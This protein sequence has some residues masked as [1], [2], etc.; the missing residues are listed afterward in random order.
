MNTEKLN[1]RQLITITAAAIFGIDILRVQQRIVLLSGQDAW[2]SITIGGLLTI[3]A[4]VIAYF[5]AA[6]YPDKD[7]PEIIIEICGKFFGKIILLSVCAYVLLYSGFSSRIFVQALKMFLVDRTPIYVLVISM[8]VAT[9]YAAY[10]GINTIGSVVDIVFPLMFI[11]IL[12]TL[13]LSISQ[14]DIIY[15]KPVL[16][17]N[18]KNVARAILPSYTRFTGYSVILYI[19]CH[20][21]RTKGS[22]RFF[23]AGLIIPIFFYIALTVVSIMVFGPKDLATLIYPTLT[24]FKTIEFPAAFMERLESFA[25]VL[26]IGIVFLSAILFN[27]TSSRNLTVLF[28]IDDKYRRYVALAQFPILIFIALFPDTGLE[29]IDFIGKLAPLQNILGLG[30]IPVLLIIGL[31][32]KRKEA[33]NEA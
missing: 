14:A 24:L 18:T 20:T 7:L 2:I 3:A 15:I 28:S 25:A 19:F 33:G 11:T 27:Y 16:F 22:I 6:I 21:K 31:I 30:V 29:V 17:E 12:A 1:P 32:K 8:G 23:L 5:L 9:T 4:G 13:L 10:K 26:W